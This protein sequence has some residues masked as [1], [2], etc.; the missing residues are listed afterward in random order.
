MKEHEFNLF[1][2]LEVNIGKIQLTS[3]MM[4]Y[5]SDRNNDEMINA[6]KVISS[7]VSN[8]E[9]NQY[10][11]MD[12]LHD[13]ETH[14]PLLTCLL[15]AVGYM[16][17]TDLRRR[18]TLAT[19]LFTAHRNLNHI[20][21]SLACILYFQGLS[22]EGIQLLNQIGVVV[23]DSTFRRELLCL[24]GMY[25]AQLSQT[26]FT[27]ETYGIAY[28]NCN[29]MMRKWDSTPE[30]RSKQWNFTLRGYYEIRYPFQDLSS[31]PMIS[32][33][34]L[35][36]T[37]FYPSL[38]DHKWL[39]CAS[40]EVIENVFK[41]QKRRL[42]TPRGNIFCNYLSIE[43][44]LDHNKAPWCMYPL[45][46]V[47]ADE[48][49]GDGNI[50]VLEQISADARLDD[51]DPMRLLVAGDQ[52]TLGRIQTAKIWRLTDVNPKE[53]L[54]WVL[55]VMGELHLLM[56]LIKTIRNTF[57]KKTGGSFIVGSLGYVASSISGEML[58]RDSQSH[59]DNERYLLE[60]LK[61]YICVMKEE[62]KISSGEQILTELNKSQ[63]DGFS[64][65]RKYIYQFIQLMLLYQVTKECGRINDGAGIQVMHKVL[66]PVFHGG[67]NKNYVAELLRERIYLLCDLSEKEAYISMYNRML[68]PSGKPT[69]YIACDHAME[70]QVRTFK[71]AMLNSG[72]NQSISHYEKLSVTAKMVDD[73]FENVKK[74]YKNGE[75]GFKHSSKPISTNL[76]KSLVQTVRNH[77]WKS[78]SEEFKV[79]NIEE[80]GAYS[81]VTLAQGY[82]EKKKA[83]IFIGRTEEEELELEKEMQL[84]TD[85]DQPI[86]W[87]D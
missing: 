33:N 53:R 48:S 40:V 28:D 56:A 54:T 16:K 39:Y 55:P 25:K 85:L 80:E 60:T 2:Q 41:K 8:R 61:I 51:A 72:S 69:R 78:E 37:H 58:T 42:I 86:T 7:K 19:I 14:L 81:V 68:C 27:T 66:L 43:K 83:R 76:S 45:E 6:Q 67:R 74:G 5:I 62:L 44:L 87:D 47:D 13:I 36:L 38:N 50:K 64:H 59:H 49:T 29:I 32:P 46:M 79:P 10:S 17:S 75:T 35:N 77:V 63:T 52:G 3:M 11:T 21:R 71:R 1:E 57:W 73:E 70:M 15:N 18:M 26:A 20:Q 34:S 84:D 9:K 82:I 30:N 12:C 23:S 22:K 24:H 65:G 31:E 4:A